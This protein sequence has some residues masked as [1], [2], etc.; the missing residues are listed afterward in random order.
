MDARAWVALL[1]GRPQVAAREMFPSSGKTFAVGGGEFKFRE[2]DRIGF[3]AFTVRTWDADHNR[4]QKNSMALVGINVMLF[5]AGGFS[6]K[7]YL[8]QGFNM[9]QGIVRYP[10]RENVTFEGLLPVFSLGLGAEYRIGRHVR[11]FSRLRWLGGDPAE[12]GAPDYRYGQFVWHTGL[13]CK[14]TAPKKWK[15]PFPARS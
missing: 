8:Q 10:G 7:V 15:R 14:F 12:R 5:H 9:R 1:L 3:D 4:V 2:R 13:S 11:M 6:S